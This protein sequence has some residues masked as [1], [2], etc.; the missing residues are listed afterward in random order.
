MIFFLFWCLITTDILWTTNDDQHSAPERWK[1]KKSR[2]EKIYIFFISVGRNWFIVYTRYEYELFIDKSYDQMRVKSKVYGNERECVRKKR[3]RKRRKSKI[4]TCFWRNLKMCTRN[5]CD[6]GCVFEMAWIFM[7][8]WTNKSTRFK[9]FC[10]AV[11]SQTK[12]KRAKKQNF[13]ASVCL[14]LQHF[15]SIKY[16]VYHVTR[17]YAFDSQQ[18]VVFNNHIRGPNQYAI[19]L[20]KVRPNTFRWAWQWMPWI[21][22]FPTVLVHICLWFIIFSKVISCKTN[23]LGWWFLPFSVK[24]F[25]IVIFTGVL[26]ARCRW[27]FINVNMDNHRSNIQQNY[28]QL[29]HNT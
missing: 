7:V 28:R 6:R 12:A 11:E 8:A 19:T 27:K 21:H 16:V 18:S 9:K 22:H 20:P 4:K 25:C 5:M 24:Q 1:R 14:S 13:F 29:L 15:S 26:S 23:W 17:D 3:Q 2:F 10:V